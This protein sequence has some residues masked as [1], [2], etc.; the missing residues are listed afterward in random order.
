MEKNAFHEARHHLAAASCILDK[1]EAEI[2]QQEVRE[3]NEEELAAKYYF[4][5]SNKC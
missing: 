5:T 4:I 1:Y 3:E 2:D